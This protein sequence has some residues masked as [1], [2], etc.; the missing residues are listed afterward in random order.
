MDKYKDRV[1]SQ[2]LPW[3]QFIAETQGGEIVIAHLSDEGKTVGYFTGILVKKFGFKIMGSPFPGWTTPYL[4]FNLLPD[5]SRKKAVA[6][7]ISFIFKELG[8]I[9]LELADPYLCLDDVQELGFKSKITQTYV[10]DLTLTEETLFG[11]MQSACRRCIR[12]AEKNGIFIEEASPAGFSEE[13]FTHLTD[14]FAKQNLK[15]TYGQERIEKLLKHLYPTGDLLLLR[16]RDVDGRSIATGIYP[17]F[18]KMSY[19][20]GNASLRKYQQ[21]RPNEAMHW[22]AMRYWKNRGVENHYWGGG[23]AYKEKYGGA[24]ISTM[25]FSLSKYRII[26]AARLV[27]EKIYYYQ[28]TVK[29]K[30]YLRKIASISTDNQ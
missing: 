26:L 5:I 10:S 4:G 9:H 20:F 29:R 6:V 27:A 11:K 13:Y 16:A 18:N 7:L 8:C 21:A 1:F 2:R 30:L 25:S 12:K 23:G 28:R 19:F 15:P 3:L 14:V 22:Y 24:Q 17:G